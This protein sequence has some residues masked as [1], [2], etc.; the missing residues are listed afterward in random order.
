MIQI[1]T[2]K[3]TVT[4]NGKEFNLGSPE[5]FKIVSDIWL[6]SGWDV[7]YVYSFAW[8]GRPIIQLP[9][10]I[11]RIQE[12]IFKLKPDVIIE[13]GVAHGG[14]LML[15]ATLCKAMGKG[16]VIG[17]DIE[18]R[19]NNRKAIEEHLLYPYISL[20]EG[21]S[22]DVAIFEKVKS[23]VKP[24]DTVLILLDSNHSYSHVLNELR[25]Y[26][27]LVSIYSYIVATDG[28]ME[29]LVGAPRTNSDWEHN[30]P[31]KAAKQFVIENENFIFEEPDFPFNEGII[32]NR[33]TY[34]PCAFIKRI[35]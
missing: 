28:I 4:K 29:Y 35:K 11:I 24:D 26:S 22:T 13:T 10:D 31:L 16:K 3:G 9:E 2:Q 19:Q 23:H 5:A 25:I 7:K 1:N 8:M 33:V 20:I 21:S 14:S 6:R 34:W 30:N 18:I 27:S 15:Y 17:I 32:K 12:V